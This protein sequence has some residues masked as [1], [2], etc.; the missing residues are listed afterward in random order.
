[1]D[2]IINVLMENPYGVVLIIVALF[3]ECIRRTFI[4]NIEMLFMDK[5]E[6]AKKFMASIIVM[7]FLCLVMNYLLTFDVVLVGT[8]IAFF[9]LF[10]WVQVIVFI[11]RVICSR[12]HKNNK[13]VEINKIVLNLRLLIIL[14]AC[15]VVIYFVTTERGYNSNWTIMLISVVETFVIY[16]RC[17][18][19]EFKELEIELIKH[20]KKEKFFIYKK[21]NDEECLSLTDLWKICLI[22]LPLQQ[23]YLRK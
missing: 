1:M 8:S 10:F 14:S 3:A 19:V 4:S 16:I 7:L 6:E 11:V 23:P 5:K 15:P 18:G 17:V 12:I 13:K 9:L 20:D 2:K 21:I 22:S